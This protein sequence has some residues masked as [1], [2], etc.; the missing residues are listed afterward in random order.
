MCETGASALLAVVGLL[1][2]DQAE[3]CRETRRC[4]KSLCQDTHQTSACG[5]PTRTTSPLVRLASRTL[6]T[7]QQQFIRRS[8]TVSWD[9]L[10]CSARPRSSIKERCVQGGYQ[11]DRHPPVTTPCS[12]RARTRHGRLA[13]ACR[14]I[15]Q[16]QLRALALGKRRSRYSRGRHG[17]PK[18]VVNFDDWL[19]PDTSASIRR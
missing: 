18:A 9:H 2:G 11:D 12:S 6:H 5:L 8:D 16:K 19:E 14:R 17:R 10:W 15:M 7:L 3:N 13:R 4:A 1:G